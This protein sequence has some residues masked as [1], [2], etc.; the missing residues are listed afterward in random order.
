[1][2]IGES[3]RKLARLARLA[4]L[5]LSATAVGATN[6]GERASIQTI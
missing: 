6:N 5:A 4:R 3:E 2:F 1:M